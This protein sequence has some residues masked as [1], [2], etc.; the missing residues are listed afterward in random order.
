[1]NNKQMSTGSART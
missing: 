1:M